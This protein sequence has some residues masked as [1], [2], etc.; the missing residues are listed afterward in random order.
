M[1][2]YNLKGVIKNLP[3]KVNLLQNANLLKEN[4]LHSKTILAFLHKAKTLK[5]YYHR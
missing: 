5:K 2:I 4:Y 1:K 3:K